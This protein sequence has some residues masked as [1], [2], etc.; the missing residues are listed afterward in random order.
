MINPPSLVSA[1]NAFSNAAF[2]YLKVKNC[3][4][5][6]SKYVANSSNEELTLFKKL[7]C[8]QKSTSSEDLNLS[9]QGR[10][11]NK[12]QLIPLMKC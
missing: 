11:D 5:S 12:C 6:S 9:C 7:M 1:E 4:V 3:R 8:L 10:V 2:M